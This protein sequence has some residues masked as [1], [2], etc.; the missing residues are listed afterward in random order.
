MPIE[1]MAN[2]NQDCLACKNHIN[3]AQGTI[4][5]LYCILVYYLIKETYFL[6]SKRL[7]PGTKAFYGI[8][9]VFEFACKLV[10]T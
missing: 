10:D 4:L 6:P 2:G 7:I 8:N 3:S 9:L 1:G 5:P